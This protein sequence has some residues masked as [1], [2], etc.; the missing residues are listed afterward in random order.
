MYEQGLEVFEWESMPCF[1]RVDDQGAFPF[2]PFAAAFFL[3]T[4]YEEYLPHTRDEFGR[5]RSWESFA[6]KN[7]FLKKPVVDIWAQKIRKLIEERFPDQALPQK[8]Y[9]F[10]S[11]V[12]V[13]TAYAYRQKGVMRTMGGFLRSFFSGR[14][15][16]IRERM[17]VLLGRLPDP[18]DNF[19]YQLNLFQQFDVE[20]VYFFLVADYG[21]NDKN[22]PVS[23]PRFRSL[24]KSV[25]DQAKVGIHPS[26]NSNYDPEKLRI[27]INRLSD[28]TKREI[29]RSRQHFLMLDLP[30]TYRRLL[31]LGITDEYSMGY[32][33]E[34]G[35]RAGTCS[36]YYHYDLDM[37]GVT[38]LRVHPFAAM[39][40]TLKHHY[41]FTPEQAIEHY[42]EL[43][44]EVKRVN[45][46][47]ISLWHNDTLSDQGEWKG[48]RKVFDEMVSMAL[49]QRQEG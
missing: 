30:D 1:F 23:S 35:F 13:D 45:G 9:R 17:K 15:S 46:T 8:Q 19:D 40:V 21:L 22:I 14:F 31:D 36:S 18:F 27:E 33:S 44:D 28:I 26:F 48:W 49:P 2:D 24:I 11:T 25:A 16:A 39:E 47:F 34:T 10:L 4:R 38:K 41:Q 32:V 42:R 37:D 6:R 3:V 20:A 5:F 43:I 12:D 29:T 7:G